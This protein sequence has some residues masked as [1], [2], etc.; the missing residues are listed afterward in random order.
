[1]SKTST[2]II[3]IIVVLGVG[4]AYTYY[5]VNNALQNLEPELYDIRIEGVG[6]L[7]PS[8]DI[9]LV[10]GCDNPSQYKIELKGNLDVYYGDSHITSIHI[11]DIIFA[12]EYSTIDCSFHI[13][14]LNV[15]NMIREG[16]DE[17][18]LFS[19]SIT[20]TH[21]IFGVIPVVI[22]GPL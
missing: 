13:S 8:A 14:S 20:A 6:L 4:Y 5:Q 12:G 3:V 7:P 21:R 17:D 15:I 10:L 22:T 1:M 2:A 18:L 11:N 9:T 16:S 19:G